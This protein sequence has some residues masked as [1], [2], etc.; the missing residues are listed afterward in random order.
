MHLLASIGG[1][2]VLP[3]L[4]QTGRMDTGSI[5]M[6]YSITGGLGFIGTLVFLTG[7]FMLIRKVLGKPAPQ[8]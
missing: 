7:F 1:Y 4:I 5:G 8:V 6:G 2:I 3:I